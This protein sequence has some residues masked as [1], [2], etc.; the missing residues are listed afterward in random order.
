MVWRKGKKVGRA[1]PPENSLII[2]RDSLS[3]RNKFPVPSSLEFDKKPE[4]NSC[5]LVPYSA[6]SRRRLSLR[7]MPLVAAIVAV[8]SSPAGALDPNQNVTRSQ[9]D[10]FTRPQPSSAST[11]TAAGLPPADHSASTLEISLPEVF[12]GCWRGRVDELDT[13]Q[14]S[15][16][17]HGGE[18]EWVI[19][20]GWNPQVYEFCYSEI[21]GKMTLIFGDARSID[22]FYDPKVRSLGFYQADSKFGIESAS[23][24]APDAINIRVAMSTLQHVMNGGTYRKNTV[25]DIRGHMVSPESMMV[26]ADVEAL[27]VGYDPG[28]KATWHAQ[29]TRQPK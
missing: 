5:L 13:V 25:T 27:P 7:T 15:G 3:G 26:E 9:Q 17:L 11:P 21:G 1:L 19:R 22:L 4:G 29:F 18:P 16:F 6:G 23:A 10:E 24:P 12:K 20:E 14:T 2:K 8:L 28:W